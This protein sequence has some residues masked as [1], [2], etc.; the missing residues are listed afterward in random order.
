M[1]KCLAGY[2]VSQLVEWCWQQMKTAL[3]IVSPP[4]TQKGFAILPKRWVVERSFA[5]LGNYRRLSKDYEE[6]IPASEGMIYLASIHCLL[7]RLTV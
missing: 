6:G 5:W 7:K 4:A 3:E 1:Q 2:D